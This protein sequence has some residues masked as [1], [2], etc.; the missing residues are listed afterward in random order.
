MQEVINECM[1]ESP[2]FCVA[3]CPLHVDV[4]GYVGKIAAGE[5]QEALNIIRQDLPFPAILGRI[6]AHPC[7]DKCKRGD[8]KQPLSVAG[9]KRF[10]ATFDKESDWDLT[11]EPSKG[12]SVAIIGAGPAGAMAAYTLSKKGYDV[13][14]FEA[15]PVV[16]GMLRVGIPAYRLPRNIIDFEFSILEKLGV[17]V[18]LNTRIGKDVS[19]KELVDNFDAVFVAVGAHKSFMM[20][21]PGADLKGILPG[22]DFLRDASLGNPVNIGKKVTVIG[23]GNV[24]IDVARTAIRKGAEE[25]TLVCLE[26]REN[27]PAHHWEV[28]DAEEENIKVINSFGTKQFIGSEN[29][30]KIELIE[31]TSIFDGTGR[32]N[33]QCNEANTK[34]LETDTVILAIGQTVENSF[35]SELPEILA[36]NGKVSTDPVTLQTSITKVFAGGDAVG[37]PL[38]AIEAIAQGKKAAISIDKFF[39]GEDLTIG[40]EN[41][42]T[43]ETKLVKDLKES[44]KGTTRKHIPR[45]PV[46]ARQNNFEEVEIGFN[47]QDALEEAS[48]CL[49]CECKLCMKQCEMLTDYCESPKQMME[50]VMEGSVD[51]MVPYSCNMCNI[52]TIHCP[53][54]FKFAEMF[55]EMRKELVKSGDGPLK[56]HNPIKMHQKL[57]FSPVFNITK[58]D[59]NAGFTKR[60]F[61]P[62]CAL[63]SYAPDVVGNILEYLQEKLPGTGSVLKCCG[64]PTNA[65]GQTEDFKERYAQLAAAFDELGAEEI[66][67]ACQSCYSTV[68]KMSPDKK[69]KSLYQL[70]TEIGIPEDKKGIANGRVFALHDSCVTRDCPHIHDSVRTLLTEMGAEIEE[71]ENSRENARCCGFGGMVVPANPELSLR[72]MKRRTSEAKSEDMVTYCAACRESMVRGGKNAVHL[73]DIMFN[74]GCLDRPLPTVHGPIQSWINRFKAKQRIKNSHLRV[75]ERQVAA[76]KK[77]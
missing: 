49:Q 41:E 48:R 8:E 34:V 37:R 51:P 46:S 3:T 60:V 71:L 50:K 43:Y 6:C 15:L 64:K 27:M 24:A 23:G 61:M 70:L 77:K 75:K 18:K 30:E 57:G 55:M 28:E 7:E 2:A 13:T 25:V 54:D 67:C 63:P 10:A 31:C 1:G 11:K 73:M 56:G 21:V 26:D 38:I 32:F 72:N 14:V 35:A 39:N 33:P 45:I 53:R 59:I 22:A 69:V 76:S 17:K 62:G 42:E 52:C 4:K 20:N 44:E 9:L 40:R 68:K 66:I 74:D 58:P 36:P 29:I 12:K 47:E 5:Y 65:L 19:L 16:G